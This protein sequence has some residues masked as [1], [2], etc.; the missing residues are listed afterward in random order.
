MRIECLLLLWYSVACGKHQ[1]NSRRQVGS[2][3]ASPLAFCP[4]AGQ[5]YSFPDFP[6]HGEKCEMR[7]FR[8]YDTRSCAASR[9]RNTHRQVG[10]ARASP[11]AFSLIA[12][13]PRRFSLS[14]RHHHEN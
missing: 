10:S 6:K 1:K 8:G 12:S 7:V 11:I 4:V 9:R 14:R 3:R 13:Q 5:P 2:A